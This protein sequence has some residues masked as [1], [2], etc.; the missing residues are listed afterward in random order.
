MCEITCDQ[1]ISSCAEFVA[2]S[3]AAGDNWD[4]VRDAAHV[5]VQTNTEIS[6]TTKKGD[7][8]IDNLFRIC[9][10]V[11]IPFQQ[12]YPAWFRG[13]RILLLFC[14]ILSLVSSLVFTQTL[15]TKKHASDHLTYI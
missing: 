9:N 3:A 7:D 11:L 14:A 12:K 2:L 15:R 5:W 10:Q 4:I 6:V 13:L 8:V 1:F